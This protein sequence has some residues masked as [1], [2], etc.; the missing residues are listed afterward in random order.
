M[1]R[2]L[3]KLSPEILQEASDWFVE[4]SEGTIDAEARERF[5]AWL[6][7]S[8]EH[9]E[10]YLKITALWEEAPLLEKGRTLESDD[11]V[12]KARG[13]SNVTALKPVNCSTASLEQHTDEKP[14]PKS[15]AS[16]NGIPVPRRT[17]SAMALAYAACLGVLLVGGS[18]LYAQRGTYST[19]IGEARSVR[20]EDGSTVELNS[21]SKVRVR[22]SQHR[23]DVELLAGQ[24]LFLVAKDKTRPFIVATDDTHVRALGTQFDVYRKGDGTVVTVLDGLVAV[25]SNEIVAP[26]QP[27]STPP[28][29][30]T[31]IAEVAPSS[32][33]PQTGE[34]LLAAGEQLTVTPH[35]VSPPGR[36]DLA[37]ASAWTQGKI[38]FQGAPLSEVAAEFNRYNTRQ[39]VIVDSALKA[40]KISGVFSSTD[41]DSLLRFLRDLPGIHVMEMSDEIRIS[42]K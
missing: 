15:A 32:L 7:R 17:V 19:G 1:S 30:Q 5:D 40:V 3:R 34:I 29:V 4:F 35:A 10:A 20:L 22:F 26:T 14:Q 31:T 38:A 11:L 6:R 42:R 24:A 33:A 9:V 36:A 37:I 27:N 12:A 13:E 18:W 39:L 41:P 25:L 28:P 21:R 2:S 16:P 8:P 23:R